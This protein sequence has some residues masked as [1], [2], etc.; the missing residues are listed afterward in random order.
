ME[1]NAYI[2]LDVHNEAIAAAIAEKGQTGDVR[3]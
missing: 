2:G 1:F 3:F